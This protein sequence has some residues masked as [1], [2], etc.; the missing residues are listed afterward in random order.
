MSC[1]YGCV[2]LLIN[3]FGFYVSYRFGEA[4]V[5]DVLERRKVK[6]EQ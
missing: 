4:L 1:H 6:L 3:G 2:L 5:D